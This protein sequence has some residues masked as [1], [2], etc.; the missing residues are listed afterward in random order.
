MPRVTTVCP[1]SSSALSGIADSA[2]SNAGLSRH[3]RTTAGSTSERPPRSVPIHTCASC[4]GS[5]KGT[6]RR[7]N[8]STMVNIA[9]VIPIPSASIPAAATVNPRCTASVRAA[10]LTSCHTDSIG[11]VLSCDER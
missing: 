7:I 9:V 6:G 2:P 4:F 8:E 10:C 1:V 3:A 5:R 11:I